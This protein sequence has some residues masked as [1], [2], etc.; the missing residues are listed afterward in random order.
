MEIIN[1]NCE[2]NKK[3]KTK[4][5]LNRH[6]KQCSIIIDIEIPD[7]N[8]DILYNCDC[9][10]V[11]KHR[12]S[13]SRHKGI[14]ITNKRA[15]VMN[16]VTNNYN[17]CYDDDAI[18]GKQMINCDND[19]LVELIKQNEDIKDIKNVIKEQT[20]NYKNELKNMMPMINNLNDDTM[21]TCSSNRFNLNTFLNNTCN[22]TQNINDLFKNIIITEADIDCSLHNGFVNGLCNIIKVRLDNIPKLSHPLYCSDNKRDVIYIRENNEWVKD[23]NNIKTIGYFEELSDK[24]YKYV[25]DVWFNKNKN[26]ILHNDDLKVKHCHY[27]LATANSAKSAKYKQSI[28]NVIKKYIIIDKKNGNI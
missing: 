22:N 4:R 5:S 19:I 6:K 27:I 15:C 23:S 24:Q 3:Y 20:T 17:T 8:N 10:N 9:G 14:C 26:K 12:S 13:F 2:C 21:N 25:K 11:Y 7:N 16:D 1:Y 28:I 18:N